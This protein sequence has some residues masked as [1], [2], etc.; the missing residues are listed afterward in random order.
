MRAQPCAQGG[1]GSALLGWGDGICAPSMTTARQWV[2]TGTKNA[3]SILSPQ[4][5]AVFSQ[6]PDRE[7]VNTALTS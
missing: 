6:M 7:R 4:S 3:G 1:G 5:F 2:P